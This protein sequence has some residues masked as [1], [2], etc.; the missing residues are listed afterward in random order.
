LKIHTR[1]TLVARPHKPWRLD[2]FECGLG[3]SRIVLGDTG[4][5]LDKGRSADI[6]NAETVINERQYARWR[7]WLGA[8]HGVVQRQCCTRIRH[9][10]QASCD[11]KP[12]LIAGLNA[13]E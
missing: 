3:T 2:A 5:R 9:R 8:R 10:S 11:L 1:Q 4:L 7:I 6:V 12:L 13:G